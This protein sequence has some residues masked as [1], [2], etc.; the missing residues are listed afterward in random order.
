MSKEVKIYQSRSFGSEGE[1]EQV[2]Y[3][4]EEIKGEKKLSFISEQKFKTLFGQLVVLVLLTVRLMT[5]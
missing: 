3:C 1:P 5:Y 2:T 4:I